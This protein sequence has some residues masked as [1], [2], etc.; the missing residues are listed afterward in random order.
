[1]HE[2]DDKTNPL[3]KIYGNDTRGA[4]IAQALLE[5]LN[6]S[7]QPDDVRLSY[8]ALA[9]HLKT[10]YLQNGDDTPSEH[11]PE[12]IALTDAQ[13][14]YGVMGD[15]AEQSLHATLKTSAGALFWAVEAIEYVFERW[16]IRIIDSYRGCADSATAGIDIRRAADAMSVAAEELGPEGSGRIAV[17][18]RKRLE[19][20][21]F[22]APRRA[23]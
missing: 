1:M 3:G 18:I 6:A 14:L 19:R 5:A 12:G 13:D 4:A 15:A 11:D 21:R 16:A 9:E 17:D 22:K 2:T 10:R 23:N 20:L 8:C 7:E